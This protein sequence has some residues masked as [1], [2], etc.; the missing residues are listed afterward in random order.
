M[1]SEKKEKKEKWRYWRKVIYVAITLLAIWWCFRSYWESVVVRWFVDLL[2]EFARDWF[3]TVGFFLLSGLAI[4]GVFRCRKNGFCFGAQWVG[5]SVAVLIIWLSYR[6]I[7]GDKTPFV[8]YP[9]EGLGKIYYVD[10][11]AV[12]CICCIATRLIK[13]KKMQPEVETKGFIKDEPIEAWDEDLLRR[14]PM[15]ESLVN[16]LMNTKVDKEAFTLGIAASWGE[17]KTSFM[18]LMEQSLKTNY[19]DRV[20]IMNFNPWLYGKEVDLLH[21]FFGELRRKIAPSNGKLSRDLRHYADALSN[22]ETPWRQ[23]FS[24]LKVGIP[25]QNIKE[26]GENI[27][28]Q[29][30]RLQKKIVIFVDD[31]DRLEVRRWQKYFNWFGMLQTFRTCILWWDTI[32]NM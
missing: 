24:V 16:R 1:E 19:K 2:S 18:K 28:G 4:W 12:L 20:I 21:V 3:T 9:I 10:L 31:I 32:K 29:I 14:G 5:L 13:P 22:I 6:F 15:A 8:F 17:G 7:L 26:Q 27:S 11:I 30:K 23:V 25:S